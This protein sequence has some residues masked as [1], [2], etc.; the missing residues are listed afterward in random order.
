M[1]DR[2]KLLAIKKANPSLLLPHIDYPVGFQGKLETLKKP[3]TLPSGQGDIVFRDRRGEPLKLIEIQ[4]D[5]AVLDGYDLR[6]TFVIVTANDVT[7]RNC[8]ADATSWYTIDQYSGFSGLVV[9]Y[10]TFTGGREADLAAFVASRDGAMTVR[11]N[12]FIKAPADVIHTVGGL[13]EENYISG[14]GYAE[15]AHADAIWVSQSLTP[16]MI[17]RGNFIDWTKQP[18]AVVLPNNAVRIAAEK[19]P[20]TSVLVENNVLLGGSFTVSTDGAGNVVR[21]NIIDEGKWGALY[22]REQP[23]DLVYENNVRAGTGQ[24]WQQ[25]NELRPPP[26]DLSERRSDANGS[27]QVVLG[28]I[29]EKGLLVGAGRADGR[30][31]V[32]VMDAVEGIPCGGTG[33]TS[34]Y[35]CLTL[36]IDM[37]PQGPGL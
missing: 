2:S 33:Q 19:G 20:I 24:V 37:P 4:K 36:A 22:P 29:D 34:E 28:R 25:N 15:G 14:G 6:G 10:C 16:T 23:P 5:G 26:P 7:V 11:R 32:V 13:V 27:K 31:Q 35:S 12:E 8:L 1:P 30:K 17:I 18:G 9:E 3:T 21:K